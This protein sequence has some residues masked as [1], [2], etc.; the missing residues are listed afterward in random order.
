MTTQLTLGVQLPQT[1]TL[2]AFVGEVNAPVKAAVIDLVDGRD[3]RL[4]IHGPANSGKTHLLQAACR[5]LGDAGARAVYLPLSQISDRVPRLLDG[6]QDMDCVCADDVDSIAGDREAE[7]ALLS[8]SDGL[9]AS[10]ARFLAAGR[11]SPRECG[12]TLADLASRL[13]WGGAIATAELD[14][15]DKQALLRERAAQRGMILP[16]ATARWVLR[17]GADDVPALMTIL[18][19]LDHA[20]LAAHRRLTIPFVKQALGIEQP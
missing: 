16:P 8:L 6:L 4:F 5:A 13:L 17:H 18:D 20:S 15:A 3:E 14:A 10:G 19:T 2:A 1:A 7:I 11:N 9:R 12:L